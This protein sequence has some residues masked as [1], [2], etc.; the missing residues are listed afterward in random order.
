MD[1][2]AKPDRF[3]TR[4]WTFCF[5]GLALAILL[6]LPS[7]QLRWEDASVDAAALLIAALASGLLRLSPLMMFVA[8]GAAGGFAFP[9]IF[10]HIVSL[11]LVLILALLAVLWW[12]TPFT[13][14]VARPGL[15]Y[16][17]RGRQRTI[18]QLDF[19]GSKPLM[20]RQNI[21]DELAGLAEYADRFL[22]RHGIRYIAVYGTV[23]GALRHGGLIPWDDDVDFSVYRPED[24]ERLDKDFDALAADAARDGF[25]LFRHGT[26]WKMAPNNFWRYPA[27][28]LYVKA[29]DPD[30][31]LEPA[32]IAWEDTTL[33][34]APDC[35]EWLAKKYGAD[36]LT[37]A[38]HG[39][40]FWDSGF[41]PAFMTRLFG[42][43]VLSAAADAVN[44]LFAPR[45][46]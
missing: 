25:V 30:P 15:T 13:A 9:S 19:S 27:V 8:A 22:T 42:Y 41:V 5:L 12:N 45:G 32:R 26:Y 2:S 37:H 4:D 38:V 46:V 35:R 18:P 16:S 10:G 11:A 17:V 6:T 24:L 20:L 33:C 14:I 39:I 29:G 34:V 44:F 36:A 7:P 31:A 28:D 3:I 23:L 40:P 21:I 1:Q 43:R